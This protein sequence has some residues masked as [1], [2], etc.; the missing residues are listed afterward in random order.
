VELTNTAGLLP[1]VVPSMEDKGTLDPV[2]RG[3]RSGRARGRFMA[4]RAGH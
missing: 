2:T 4:R 1:L 3:H